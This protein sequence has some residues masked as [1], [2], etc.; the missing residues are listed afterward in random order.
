[1]KKLTFLLLAVLLTSISFGQSVEVKDNN[2]ETLIKINDE[3]TDK[4]S[5]TL[6]NSLSAPGIFTDKLYNVGHSL[7]WNGSALATGASPVWSLNGS[8]AY[9]NAGNVGIGITTPV[10]PLTIYNATTSN[11]LF[12]NSTTGTNTNEGFLVGHDGATGAYIWNYA[13]SPLNIGTNDNHRMMI[14]ADGNVGIGTTTPL[15]KLHVVGDFRM[16]DA[17]PY[18][19]FY[20]G[21]TQMGNIGFWTDNNL[22][23]INRGAT[24]P[25]VFATNADEKMRIT[26]DGNVGIGTTNPLSKLSIN[27]DG[28]AV[29]TVTA[30]NTDVD[31]IAIV[32]S[33]T[34]TPS[35]GIG[36]ITSGGNNSSAVFGNALNIDDVLTYG[37][38]F[39]ASGRY[40]RGVYG[41]A[42]NENGT[43]YGVYGKTNSTG[44]YGGYFEGR[45][46]F[47]NKLGLGIEIPDE[48]LH[49]NGNMRL[50]GTFEDKDGEA[51]TTGQLLSSTGTGTNWVTAE[52]PL[53]TENGSDI[54]RVSGNVGIG[55]TTP[56]HSLEVVGTNYGGH[57]SAGGSTG[58]GVYGEASNSGEG[59]NYGG[60]FEANGSFG[61]GVYGDALGYSGVGVGG[62]ASGVFGIG[63]TGY[64]S[65]NGIT[66]NTGGYFTADGTMGRGVYGNASNS[67]D[68]T[69]YGGYFIAN[70]TTGRGV[71]GNASNSGDVTNYGGYFEAN[72]QHGRGVYGIALGTDA[73]AGYFEGRGYFSGNVGIG[74]S[75]PVTKLDVDGGNSHGIRGKSSGGSTAGILGETGG[76]GSWGV[77]GYDTHGGVAVRGLT[78]TTGTAGYFASSSSGTAGYF[79]SN[80]G[81]GLI[82]EN[83][84]VGIGTS[85]PSKTLYVNGS[86]GGTQGWNASDIRY[87]KNI[88]SVTN[89]IEGIMKLRG[90]EYEWKNPSEDESTGFDNRVHYGVIAQEV[91][92]VFPNLIDNQGNTEEMKHVEYNGFT[93]IL[94]EAI[95]EQQKMIEDLQKEVELL[96][97][98]VN[99]KLKL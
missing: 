1:M 53:W 92:E 10:A 80:S 50:T 46:Y 64:A 56:T 21:T 76:S 86:A 77:Y 82:V 43:N 97:K 88:S 28:L 11:V 63:V 42:T 20:S 85:T 83:G 3:G 44:G 98:Q 81:Y 47:S 90:V 91:E 33:A 35:V 45:G 22:N 27:D 12:Q 94:I 70:G 96:K 75:S 55:T 49:V 73:Y 14:S 78:T 89:S 95:K 29:A 17:S 66:D 59:T 31:G 23:I 62:N 30:L 24:S 16:D 99:N 79:T 93:A 69:N 65:N 52:S 7:F 19:N 84:N 36:G 61:R 9:Y 37:G 57:F 51:G 60:Y 72:G 38:H 40:S 54:Y 2:D 48:M 71:Y 32:G 15:E 58:R 13:N 87:K 5:I 41:E 74:T 18:L 67:G 6:Q 34:A 25:I 8:N 68:D 39:V 4:S 26:A